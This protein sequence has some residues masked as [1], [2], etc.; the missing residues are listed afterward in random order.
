MAFNQFQS[1]AQG[2]RFRVD[3]S[4]LER[5]ESILSESQSL[6][7]LFSP[8]MQTV[9]SDVLSF[10]N[11]LNRTRRRTEDRDYTAGSDVISADQRCGSEATGFDEISSATDL[12]AP[13]WA[14]PNEQ[15]FGSIDKFIDDF[16]EI[17]ESEAEP[18]PLQLSL[19]LR[20]RIDKWRNNYGEF[21]DDNTASWN[22]DE[23][24]RPE[25]SDQ[26]PQ[27]K[28]YGND[29]LSHLSRKDYIKVR[30]LEKRL[31]SSLSLK[32]SK[33][34]LILLYRNKELSCMAGP[35]RPYSTL[36][37]ENNTYPFIKAAI[38]SYRKD[39]PVLLKSES[40]VSSLVLC[41]GPS[42]DN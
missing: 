40:S 35:A 23:N 37:M 24:L 8:S 1:E 4:P 33:L 26:I 25:N 29:L 34:P 19:D 3:D 38:N 31:R 42:S 16:D 18:E 20:R 30:R 22:L 13:L 11:D 32:S 10:S 5:T 2:R 39:S 12:G 28:Y 9:P 15:E 6:W 7:V 17:N 36:L 41:G 27:R 14:A 21:I